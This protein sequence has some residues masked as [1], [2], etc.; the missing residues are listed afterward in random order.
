[1]PRITIIIV[2]YQV[3]EA[4]DRCLQSLRVLAEAADIAVWVVDNASSDG[5]GTMMRE[6]FPEVQFLPLPDNIGY[7]RA[8]NIAIR[9]TDSPYVLLLNPDTVVP[10]DTLTPLLAALEADP[11]LGGITAKVLLEDGSLDAACRRSF[12]RLR[13]LIYKQLGLPQLFPRSSEFNHYNLGHLPEDLPA[14][15]ECVM[16]AFFLLKRDVL[17]QVGLFDDQFFLYGEDLDLCRRIG[18]AGW[19]IRYDPRVTITHIKG[20]SARKNPQV[21]IREFHRSWRILF[22]KH[23]APTVPVWQ[24][25]VFNWVITAHEAWAMWRWRR[26]GGKPL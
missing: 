17:T 16:G 26:V 15:V 14:D 24:R 22:A 12:P 18:Q 1:M 19:R 9:K 10:A 20:A 13:D 6:A 5:T 4:L 25:K 23:W 8:N 11:R 7:G 21:A 2:S 3:R